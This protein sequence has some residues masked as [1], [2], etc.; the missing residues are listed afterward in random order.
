MHRKILV[1]GITAALLVV[2][3]VPAQAADT[4]TG[5]IVEKA[6][7][8]NRGAHGEDHA[9]CA[10]RCI[11]RGGDVGLLTADGD[12]YILKAGDDASAFESLK[13]MAGKQVAVTGE[14]G[15]A[16]GDYKTLVVSAAEPATS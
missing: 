2:A 12:L 9:S 5:E 1:A 4:V 13:G 6:C 7:F 15:D 3:A 10:A 16:D 14:W 8:V 11:E